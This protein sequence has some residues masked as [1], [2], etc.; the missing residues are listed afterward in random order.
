MALA[1]ATLPLDVSSHAPNRIVARGMAGSPQ[2]CPA[3][4]KQV[5]CA[6]ARPTFQAS[7]APVSIR[8]TA[9]SNEHTDRVVL[10]TS[11]G[12]RTLLLRAHFGRAPPYTLSR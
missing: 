4:E 7:V 2:K 5:D 11:N 6:N 3:L 9:P 10:N 8:A 12:P 1:Q